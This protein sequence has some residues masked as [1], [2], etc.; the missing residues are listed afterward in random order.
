MI[1]VWA[2]K[3]IDMKPHLK[4]SEQGKRKRT[5]ASLQA[6]GKIQSRASSYFGPQSSGAIFITAIA[7][8]LAVNNLVVTI[9]PPHVLLIG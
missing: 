8:G 3:L 5:F 9:Y 1:A 4:L 6:T 2:F 7:A